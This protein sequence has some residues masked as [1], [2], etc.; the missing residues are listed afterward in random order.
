MSRGEREVV[1]VRG[2]GSLK[3]FLVGALVGGVAALLYAPESGEQTRRRLQRKV[4]ALRARAEE[5]LDDVAGRVA[6]RLRGVADDL[7]DAFEDEDEAA[8]PASPRADLERRLAAA[9][10]RRAR[11]VEEPGA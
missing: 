11:T 1:V 8:E 7:E 3:W 6:T 10:A 4:R 9:R 2:D 5:A